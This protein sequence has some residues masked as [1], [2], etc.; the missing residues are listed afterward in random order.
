MPSTWHNGRVPLSIPFAHSGNS[1]SVSVGHVPHTNT[2]RTSV[3][4]IRGRTGG[5][6]E[7]RSTHPRTLC[8]TRFPQNPTLSAKGISRKISRV[9]L[10]CHRVVLL[11]L[12]SIWSGAE[13]YAHFVYAN[14]HRNRPPSHHAAFIGAID[15]RTDGRADGRGPHRGTISLADAITL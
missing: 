6:K 9:G 1:P 11:T 5:R 3:V 7:E 8:S 14:A 4:V 2:P 10:S 13:G 15:G 12:Y